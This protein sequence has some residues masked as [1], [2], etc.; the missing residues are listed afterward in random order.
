MTQRYLERA[1]YFAGW[2]EHLA[3]GE[4]KEVVLCERSIA[5]YRTES[6][7]VAAIANRC[8]HR[9]AP[10]HLGRVRGEV[11][12]CG[13]HGLQ[14]GREGKCVFNPHT[15]TAGP[16]AAAVRAYPAVE[17]YGAIWIWFSQDQVADASLI[18][19]LSVLSSMPKTALND[20]PTMKVR[21]N[22]E[23]VVDNLF[24]P[25]HAEYLHPGTLGGSGELRNR[26]PSLKVDGRTVE[27]AWF[28]EGVVAIPVFK[29][30][31]TDTRTYDTW[32][33]TRWYAPG[34]VCVAGGVM[35]S[36]QPRDAGIWSL[37]YH[38][39]M[40]AEENVTTYDARGTRS[41][42]VDDLKLTAMMDG[43][44]QNAFNNEDKP[45]I[46]AQ[47]RML[48]GSDFGALKPALFPFDK[49]AVQVRRA[50]EALRNAV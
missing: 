37:V 40:P 7:G 4:A 38:I 32:M 50:L 19:D 3:I 49:P 29:N 6:G 44:F 5:V 36:G 43:V 25:T 35:P 22:Y 17:R 9:F 1:W 39:L 28:Y 30:F 10:L 12:E 42:S 15:K 48:G 11:L 47:Q 34:I 18:P 21:G 23:L 24:D 45:M 41:F 20:L 27:V 2:T 31:V 33:S 14:F 46:E 13:Y 26:E 8:P 16:N